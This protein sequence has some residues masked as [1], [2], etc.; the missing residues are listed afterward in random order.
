MRRC[1]TD[2]LKTAR[3]FKNARVILT[4]LETGL[5]STLASPPK[6]PARISDELDLDTGAVILLLDA[7]VSLGIAKHS[8]KGYS[9]CP[10]FKAEMQA[11]S[12]TT[13]AELRNLQAEWRDWSRLSEVIQDGRRV[14]DS[15]E[16]QERSERLKTMFSSRG[17][18]SST[19]ETALV[20]LDGVESLLDLGGSATGDA[21]AFAR[22]NP[23]L[24]ITLI[25]LPGLVE[26]SERLMRS[27]GIQDSIAVVGGNYLLDTI[28]Y[29]FDVVW[30]SDVV[31]QQTH[32]QNTLLVSRAAKALNPNGRLIIR[33]CLYDPQASQEEICRHRLNMLV[34]TQN[35]QSYS[36]EDVQ[37]WLISAGVL[38]VSTTRIGETALIVGHRPA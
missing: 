37:G 13:L 25:E 23:E 6:P 31:R 11:Q 30:I 19:P 28:G 35:A 26:S 17:S 32:S 14:V 1:A 4:A 2:Y 33:D 36:T 20:D 7:L 9:L 34:T 22:R 3:D 8:T 10:T 5:L 21:V 18:I 24:K 16:E 29:G 12:S 38:L 15:I 27:M